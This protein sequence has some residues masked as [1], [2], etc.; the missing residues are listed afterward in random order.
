MNISI[1]LKFN[2]IV[3]SPPSII[4][5]A[6]KEIIF[7]PRINIEI[8]CVAKGDPAPRYTW[9]KDKR[10]Y[11][12]SSQN[13]RVALKSNAG[14]LIITN[15]TAADQ[16]WYQCNATNQYGT[17]LS[18]TTRLRMAELSQFPYMQRPKIVRA[19]RGDHV[20]LDC[21]PPTGVPDPYIYWSVVG[22]ND[23]DQFGTIA[24][25]ARVTQDYY[26]KQSYKQL[27]NFDFVF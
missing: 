4:R 21:T 27:K 17:A 6:L 26:G 13:N 12:P 19:R 11:N 20:I 16:G 24:V 2:N 1:K 8:P 5:Q 10:I 9:T 7:D 23:R 22:D 25:S 14:T 15:P 18:F 3:P